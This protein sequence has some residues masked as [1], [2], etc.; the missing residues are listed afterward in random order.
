MSIDMSPA[1]IKRRKRADMA[2]GQEVWDKMQ[3]KKAEAA[4]KN[5]ANSQSAQPPGA[6]SRAVPHSTRTMGVK[7]A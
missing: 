6:P 3:A 7:L 5:A 1:A 4:R 2:F